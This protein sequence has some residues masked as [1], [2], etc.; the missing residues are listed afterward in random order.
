MGPR[1]RL[2]IIVLLMALT[3]ALMG[4][5]GGDDAP[6][7]PTE[8]PGPAPTEAPEPVP[9][10]VAPAPTEEPPTPTQIP[11]QGPTGEPSPEPTEV[12]TPEPTEEPEPTPAEEPTPAPTIPPDE[13]PVPY[14]LFYWEAWPEEYS[15]DTFEELS[16]NVGPI[17]DYIQDQGYNMIQLHVRER[18]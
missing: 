3:V 9:T 16:E 6:P 18:L 17:F 14:F 11:S 7:A 13:G 8:A 15:V 1:S 12:P 5:T 10:E 4:C 2:S